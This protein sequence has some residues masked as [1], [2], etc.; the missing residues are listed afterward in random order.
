MNTIK[1]GLIVS[2]VTAV[3]ASLVFLLAAPVQSAGTTTWTYNFTIVEKQIEYSP[4]QY[5]T[6]WTYNGEVPGP[7]IRVKVGDTVKIN[8]YNP[9]KIAHSIHV[10]GLSYN[11][12]DDGSAPPSIVQPGK[13][14]TYTFIATRPGLY[15]YH[16]HS[17]ANYPASVHVQQGLYG[18]ILVE[19]P[20]APLPDTYNNMPVKEYMVALDEVYPR[21]AETIAHGCSYCAGNQK[22]FSMN[23]RQYG[24]PQAYNITSGKIE[25]P[26]AKTGQ[27]VRFYVAN[28]GNDLHTFFIHGHPLYRRNVANLA[29]ELL[30]GDNKAFMPFDAAVLETVAQSPGD[31]YYHCHMIVHAD[32]GMNGIFRV[33]P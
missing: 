12:S 33:T 3:L 25:T 10:H 9:T 5:V 14:Y 21:L 4:G 28:T 26:T 20:A 30:D 8:L 6:A 16:C 18:G 2:L 17:S 19:D 32:N 22:Y 13:T 11:I 1:K 24:L 29:T 23:H 31:W 7:F 15:E 27:M